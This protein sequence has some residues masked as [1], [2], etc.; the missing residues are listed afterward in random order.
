MHLCDDEGNK[1][2]SQQVAPEIVKEAYARLLL[3]RGWVEN[4]QPDAQVGTVCQ[5]YLEHLKPSEP[6]GRN[7][8]GTAKTFRDRGRTLYDFCYGY[9]GK[10]FCDG[11]L[12]KRR[13][14]GEPTRLHPGFGS[15]AASELTFAHVDE[16]LSYHPT[17]GPGGKRTRL[18]TLKRAFNFAVERSLI[19]KSPLKGYKIPRGVSRVTYLTPEQEQ[20]LRA[21]ASPAF[22]EALQVCIRTGARFGI[23]FAKLERRHVKDHGDRMEWKFKPTETKNKRERVVRIVDPAVLA[24]VRRRLAENPTGPLFRNEKGNPWTAAM[25]SNNFRR[26]KARIQKNGVVLDD[27]ACMYSC[28]HTYAKRV[29]EGYW[30][31]KPTSIKTLARLMGN[32][33]QVC[34]DHYLQFS[35]ADNEMVWDAV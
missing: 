19:A 18:Q 20:A 3:S 23:E 10:Y 22:E 7:P 13:A 32:T 35:E 5:R 12:Q 4:G 29:L 1:L 30:T 14:L 15:L 8:R 27:D 21:A 2:R 6:V 28:R 25:L 17:W 16:W 33:V 26:A 31:G 34:I 11:D 9:S 24:I